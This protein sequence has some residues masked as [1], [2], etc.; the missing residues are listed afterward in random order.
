MQFAERLVKNLVLVLW[1][2]MICNVNAFAQEQRCRHLV[3]K[4]NQSVALENSG[5]YCLDTDVLI[6]DGSPFVSHGRD[7]PYYAVEISSDEVVLDLQGHAVQ[8]GDITYGI[9][10]S[11][12]SGAAPKNVEIRNGSIRSLRE[13]ISSGY[14]NA[15][16][17]SDLGDPLA[18]FSKS[19]S[20]PA[21]LEEAAKIARR[22]NESA[23]EQQNKMRPKTVSDYP[24][25][26]IHFEGLRIFVRGLPQGNNAGGGAINVQGRGTVIRNCIIETDDGNAVWIF[27][28]NAIIENNT[29][30]VHGRNRLREADAA[31]R[32]IQADGAVVRNNKIIIR[33][34]A[35]RRGISTFDTGPITVE[36]NTFYGMAAKDAVAKAFLGT[37][38]MK[39]SGSKFEPS[40]KALFDGAR[41]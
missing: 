27:G 35:N 17:L 33:D 15:V 8:S 32:L 14:T 29:I 23:F 18:S 4:R 28:P 1:L 37:L 7:R 30:I 19:G 5:A 22:I 11:V 24:D 36:N 39:E 9:A 10:I 12:S 41:Q 40:W 34:S 38:D 6:D 25:R 31:I 13:G 16:V 3:A 2:M 21:Q 26:N 20:S